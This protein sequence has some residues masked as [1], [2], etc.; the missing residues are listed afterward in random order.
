MNNNNKKNLLNA[1]A[2]SV[3]SSGQLKMTFR[4]IF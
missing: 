2:I 4:M 3:I 1:K